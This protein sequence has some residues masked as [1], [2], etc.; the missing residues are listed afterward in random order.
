MFPYIFCRNTKFRSVKI[1]FS[2][3]FAVTHIYDNIGS[4]PFISWAISMERSGYY[5][6]GTIFFMSS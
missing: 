1:T 4:L 3:T 5:F 2:C 6:F